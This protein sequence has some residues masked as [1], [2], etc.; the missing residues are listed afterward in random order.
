MYSAESQKIQELLNEL[1]S[2]VALLS[3]LQTS[4]QLQFFTKR[5]LDPNYYGPAEFEFDTYKQ[6]YRG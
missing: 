6:E 1:T 4:E 5:D 2:S 3:P